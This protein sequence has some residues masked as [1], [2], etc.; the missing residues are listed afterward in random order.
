MLARL[1][2]LTAGFALVAH[3]VFGCCWHHA[4]GHRQTAGLHQHCRLV[5]LRQHAETP[6]AETTRAVCKSHKRQHGQPHHCHAHRDAH[7]NGDPRSTPG[8]HVPLSS[9]GPVPVPCPHDSDPCDHDPC[10]FLTSFE[11]VPHLQGDL[12]LCRV[13]AD[14]PAEGTLL[15]YVDCGGQDSAASSPAYRRHAA[16]SVWQV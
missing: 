1:L 9:D 4:H 14:V 7:L 2:N 15:R 12:T 11:T 10:V 16:M 13:I 5:C 8:S 6:E 3:A